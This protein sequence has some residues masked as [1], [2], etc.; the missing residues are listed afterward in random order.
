MFES[1]DFD[2]VLSQF[3]FPEAVGKNNLNTQLPENKSYSLV[4]ETKVN[5]SNENTTEFELMKYN[6]SISCNNTVQVSNKNKPVT[7]NG[8]TKGSTVS[9]KHT[10]RKIINSH[11]DHKTKRKFPGPAGL[12]TG[13]LEE[14]KDETIG[15]ME[16]LSQ[17]IEFSQNVIQDFFESPLWLRLLEDVKVWNLCDIDPV[18]SIK[19]QALAG[20]LQRRKAQT[21]V[22]FVESVDRS[23]IDPLITLRDATGHIKCT[24]HRDAWSTFSPY[25]VSE[26]CALVLW[27]P[28]VLTTGSAFK[29]HYLNI[30]LSNIYAIY[31]SAVLKDEEK[32]LPA[33]YTWVY[34]E[35]FTVIKTERTMMDLGSNIVDINGKTGADDN[36]LLDDLDSIFSDDLF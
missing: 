29:K 13:T 9:P 22:A 21:V 2:Q 7:I 34:E 31:S 25:I 30:T 14:N 3:D 27:K 23:V 15:Q 5:K 28:T 6:I 8:G 26:Y 17:D 20:N 32:Q 18:K 16:L 24:L 19:E 11:F 35:D 4:T 36:N 1:D 33:G 12:L 10:K